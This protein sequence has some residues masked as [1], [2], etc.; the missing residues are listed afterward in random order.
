MVMVYVECQ[1]EP[2]ADGNDTSERIESMLLSA[3]EAGRLCNDPTLKFDAKAWLVLSGF[4]A[5]GFNR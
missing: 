2:S 4:A 1:G 5:A 3:Q